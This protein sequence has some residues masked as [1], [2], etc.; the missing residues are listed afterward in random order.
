[1]S[2]ALPAVA[3][4]TRCGTEKTIEIALMGWSSAAILAHI[5]AIILKRGFGCSV[6]LIPGDT[7]PTLATITTRGMPVLA[8]E[9]W[10]SSD[11]RIWT[12]A[13]SRGSVA[14]LGTTFAEGPDQGWYIPDYLAADNPGL[15]GAHDLPF[16]ASLFTDPDNPDKSRFV[17]CPSGWTCEVVN[18]NML[19]AYGLDAQF[20]PYR[21]D[22]IDALDN[23][24]ASAVAKRQ[25]ILFYRR[26][27][28]STIGDTG[29]VRLEM[30]PFDAKKY[31]CILRR[32]CADPQPTDF[33]APESV[34][35]V[36]GWLPEI[37]PEIAA[38]L[39]KMTL[40]IETV[41]DLVLWG[42]DNHA[43]PQTVARHFF[44]TRP[45]IWTNWVPEDVSE[46]VKASL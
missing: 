39:E 36:A 3:S 7:V 46:R 43:G 25:P 13:V 6:A 37:I 45:E 1:M 29:M 30:E 23:L 12:D 40:D 15:K 18:T 22:S 21:P 5:D 31:A 9:L 32:D 42:E 44:R 33:I 14:S 19:K 11:N 24:V 26:G 8:P 2:L 10:V 17:S 27:P 38:Y 28:I 35:A 20:N 4:Q 41:E 16:Y 34:K